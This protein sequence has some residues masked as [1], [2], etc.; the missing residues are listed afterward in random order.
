MAFSF[1]SERLGRAAGD[2]FAR[3]TTDDHSATP[4]VVTLLS[5]IY[6]VLVLA[7]RLGFTKWRAYALDD[8]I[9]T[10]AHVYIAKLPLVTSQSMSQS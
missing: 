7:V 10:I 6:A 2:P 8:T 4:W 1:H 5:A 3:I 9:V